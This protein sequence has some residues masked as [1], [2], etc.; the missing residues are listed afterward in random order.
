MNAVNYDLNI[1]YK[2]CFPAWINVVYTKWK[3]RHNHIMI[4]HWPWCCA[5]WLN[6]GSSPFSES[7][8]PL[9]WTFQRQAWVWNVCKGRVSIDITRGGTQDCAWG[10]SPPNHETDRSWVKSLDL[11][12]LI[13]TWDEW[14]KQYFS[15]C[16]L[17]PRARKRFSH[18][19]PAY[20]HTQ[21][22]AHTHD[23][24]NSFTKQYVVHEVHFA[25]FY[26]TLFYFI[27]LKMLVLTCWMDF[28]IH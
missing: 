18:Q 1:D 13:S 6:Q 24:N 12:F 20:T 7:P 28:T 19:N 22:H 8:P 16:Q 2:G 3:T 10:G 9:E 27:V 26:S 21:T 15:V 17:L 11:N 4:D 5:R 14:P 23:R 25:I